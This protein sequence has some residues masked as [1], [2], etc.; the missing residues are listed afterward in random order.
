MC[1]D[2]TYEQHP[3]CCVVTYTHVT[4]L[5]DMC[6]YPN[7]FVESAPMSHWTYIALN[8]DEVRRDSMGVISA[9]RN[10]DT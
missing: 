5:F 3:A 4:Y 6:M 7:M 10:D 1:D 2:H 9:H 8:I